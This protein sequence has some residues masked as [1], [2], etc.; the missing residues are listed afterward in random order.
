M[1]IQARRNCP[2]LPGLPARATGIL[3]LR[4]GLLI[5]I[6]PWF[7]AFKTFKS[8][9]SIPDSSQRLERFEQ[10]VAIE[11]LEPGILLLSEEAT[12]LV[13]TTREEKMS[14]GIFRFFGASVATML[15]VGFALAPTPA[16]AQGLQCASN[17]LIGTWRLNLQKSTITRNNGVIEPRIM[18]IAPFGDNG[19]TEVFL[20][21]RDPRLVGRW[22]MWSVQFDGKP[23]PTKGGDPRQM[24]W[25]RIDCNTFQ[26]ETLRQ[27][28]YNLPDGTVKEYVPEGRVSSGGRIT[29]SAD[30]KTLTNKHTGTL[31]NQTR[32]EDEILVFDRQ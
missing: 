11:R 5:Y 13:H 19:I 27:L 23:Y 25:T 15:F 16:P 30:G 6:R 10:S 31:G 21:D 3:L 29:V 22:E 20:N 26:H 9:K 12:R 1:T 17:P 18:I 4:A 14:S 24:R 7:N 8:F 32:Y 2:G 28:Y